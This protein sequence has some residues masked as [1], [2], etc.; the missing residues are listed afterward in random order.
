M[1]YLRAVSTLGCAEFDLEQAIDLAKRHGLGALELRALDGTLDLPGY[2]SR[3][4]RS[5]AELAERL[6]DSPVRIA[7]IDTSFRLAGH[8]P[9][10]W[11]GFLDFVPWAEALGVRWLRV[12]DGD[13]VHEPSRFDQALATL[14]RWRELRRDHRW[15]VDC[16]VETHDSLLDATRVQR[17]LA[18]APD[19][20]ILWD[21]HHTWK[22]G[23]EDPLV[24]WRA[25]RERVACIHLKDSIDQPGPEHPYSYVLPGA[26]LF[27]AAP[28][29]NVL[30]KEFGGTVSLEWERLWHPYLPPLEEALLHA[31]KT[32]WW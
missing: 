16:A 4:F 8:K 29:V 10:D 32:D 26:G 14:R 13:L 11:R 31:A 27:P 24:T 28:L 3:H 25:I 6:G 30:R 21:T 15:Q 9:D 23:G 12:F 7:V 20:S 5:P 1:S 19:T 22:L 18:V 17:L 2:F